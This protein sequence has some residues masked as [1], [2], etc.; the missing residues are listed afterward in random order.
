MRSPSW[1]WSSGAPAPRLPSERLAEATASPTNFSCNSERRGVATGLRAATRG[2]R[3]IHGLRATP[4]LRALHI[5]APFDDASAP[6]AHQIDAAQ[7]VRFGGPPEVLPA[8]LRALTADLDLFQFEV[9]VPVL[10]DAA[11]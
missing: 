8:N 10:R 3:G 11:P 2:R 5:A 1:D 4:A 7:R 6:H 9:R